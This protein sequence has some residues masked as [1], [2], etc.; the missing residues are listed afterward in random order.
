MLLNYQ[1]LYKTELFAF[2]EHIY[3]DEGDIWLKVM[4]WTIRPLW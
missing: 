3:E 4:K 1:W 2:R